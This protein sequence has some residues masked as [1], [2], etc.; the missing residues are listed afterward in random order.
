MPV[1]EVW[2]ARNIGSGNTVAIAESYPHDECRFSTAN[3]PAAIA[4]VFGALGGGV[5]I[6]LLSIRKRNRLTL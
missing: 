1:G 2:L 6:D 4:S 3:L 5:S